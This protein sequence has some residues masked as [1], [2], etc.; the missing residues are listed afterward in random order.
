MQL[1]R[2]GEKELRGKIQ[3]LG[4]R[5]DMY[6]IRK[7]TVPKEVL[8]ELSVMFKAIKKRGVSIDETLLWVLQLGLIGKYNLHLFCEMPEEKKAKELKFDEFES[9]IAGRR[10]IRRWLDEDVSIDDI[11]RIIEIAK[12]APSSCNRQLW[13]AMPIN[14]MDDKKYLLDYFPNNFWLKAPLLLLIIMDREGYGNTDKH[15]AY[16]DGGA[17]IQ[18]L[19]LS[20]SNSGYGA[21]WIGFKG[22]DTSGNLYIRKDLYNRFYKHFN[23]KESQVPISLIAIG[24]PYAVVKAPPRQSINNIVVSRS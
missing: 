16:L 19:L 8:R 24:K 1:D 4:H 3:H 18:N 5:I 6:I 23:L 20:L 13:H 21:C 15:F 11:L 9:A 12:W 7:S 14:K 2:I 10:S 22:W 17:F